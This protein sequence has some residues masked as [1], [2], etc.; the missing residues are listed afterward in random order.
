MS[1]SKVPQHHVNDS[2]GQSDQNALEL[3]GVHR[4]LLLL[5][6]FE[7]YHLLEKALGFLRIKQW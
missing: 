4:H 3:E 6:A 7:F 2:H 5:E 1:L